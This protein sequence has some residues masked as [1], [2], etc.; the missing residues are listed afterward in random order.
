MNTLCRVDSGWLAGWLAGQ[1]R[2]AWHV[3]GVEESGRGPSQQRGHGMS[4]S[5]I[6]PPIKNQT[7]RTH[8]RRRKEP[9]PLL[10]YARKQHQNPI[11]ISPL[12]HPAKPSIHHPH[13]YP[14]SR[15]TSNRHLPTQLSWPGLAARGVS[16]TATCP[17]C[18]LLLL[19][20]V[21]AWIRSAI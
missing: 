5:N 16:G 19:P 18:P 17:N 6:R 14:H 20:H 2:G 15:N 10:P 13:P 1:H 12:A 4:P 7:L 21:R 9:P 11:S 3:A 8:R